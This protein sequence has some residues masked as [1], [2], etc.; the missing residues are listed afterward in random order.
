MED[1]NVTIN[2]EDGNESSD[3][4]INKHDFTFIREMRVNQR[5]LEIPQ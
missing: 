3:F 4:L 2:V 1:G 5:N